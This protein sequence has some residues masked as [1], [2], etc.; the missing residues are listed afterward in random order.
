MTCL[1][2]SV[3]GVGVVT[4]VLDLVGMV[5]LVAAVVVALWSLSIPAAVAAGGAGLL[6]VSWL[7]DWR[8]SHARKAAS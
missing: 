7:I 1:I 5:A 8:A 4:T 6:A 3:E 2:R